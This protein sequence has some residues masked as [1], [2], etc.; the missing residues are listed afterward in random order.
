MTKQILYV[1]ENNITNFSKLEWSNL[2]PK[3]IF[4]ELYNFLAIIYSLK[5]HFYF[6]SLIF[7]L[8]GLGLKFRETKGARSKNPQ[9]PSTVKMDGGLLR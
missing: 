6:I 2:E 3:W 7:E 1:M 4:Y 8:T 9:T 5:I